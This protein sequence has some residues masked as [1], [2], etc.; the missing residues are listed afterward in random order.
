ME[1]YHIQGG[2]HIEGEYLV[3]GAKN[4][5]LPILA[6]SVITGGENFFTGCPE[7]SD[8]DIMEEILKTLGCT[9]RKERSGILVNTAG[10]MG[11]KIP[12]EL[13]K[14]MRSSIFLVGPILCRLGEVTICQPGGCA[15]GKRPIDIH[16]Y[17]LKKLGASVKEN[18]EGLTFYGK[19]LK[20]T[21]IDLPFP[22]VGATENIMM[23]ALGASGQTVIN[24]CAREPEI[25]DLQNYL[26]KCGGKIQGAGT[27]QI[28]ILGGE[29]LHGA[30]HQIMGDRVEGGTF[31]LAAAATGGCLELKGLK[32]ETL[33]TL[34]HI[35]GR[36]GCEVIGR[37][38]SICLQAPKRL[39][40]VGKVTTGPYPEFPTDLQPQLGAVMAGAL[41][42][43][44]IEEAVFEN[45]FNYTK[46]LIK[47]GGVVEI[48]QRTAIIE[49]SG[50]LTGSSVVAEDLRGGAALVIAGLAAEGE[51]IVKDIKFIERGYANFPE[52]LRKLGGNI[53]K[54]K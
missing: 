30:K 48:F 24:N 14:K 12:Q 23:A 15:I 9:V 46:Q 20:G 45:R 49:G 54:H 43:S 41:G 25:E 40:G 17:G 16:I 19:N 37:E 4:A 18:R 38:N 33:N 36:A 5:T 28:V 31:L 51:T 50:H 26:N 1:N 11:E 21:R 3:K 10:L 47:M 39:L 42:K 2:N 7:I 44:Y 8:V 34:C 27:S 6:A 13:M 22:S 53:G 32:I 35:L 29:K 52:E